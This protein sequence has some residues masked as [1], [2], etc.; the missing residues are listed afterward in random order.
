MPRRAAGGW[1]ARTRREALAHADALHGLARY[2][3]GMDSDAE[4]LV[5]E[6]YARAF[7]GQGSFTEGTNLKAWLFRI[8]RNTFVDGYRRQQSSP[9][10]AGAALPEVEAGASLAAVAPRDIQRA[11]MALSE[12]GRTAILLDLEGLTETEMAAV[13]GCA[14]GTVKSRLARARAQLRGLLEDYAR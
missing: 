10:D 7:S 1:D 13:L 11:M 2:L 4:D 6:A 9:I 8:L 12:E 5:Q 3:T 14:V